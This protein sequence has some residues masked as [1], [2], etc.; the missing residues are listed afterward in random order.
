MAKRLT[1]SFEDV[2]V[3]VREGYGSRALEPTT[4]TTEDTIDAWKESRSITDELTNEAKLIGQKKEM[5]TVEEQEAAEHSREDDRKND[6]S[7][8]EAFE[9]TRI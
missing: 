2:T 8:D 7:V 9:S 5:D 6:I 3:D 4:I 1:V